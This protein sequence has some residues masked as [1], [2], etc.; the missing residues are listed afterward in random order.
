MLIQIKKNSKKGSKNQIFLIEKK[1]D[2]KSLNLSKEQQAY[3]K[4]E[5][6][7]NKVVFTN[8]SGKITLI[9]MFKSLKDDSNKEAARKLGYQAYEA[10]KGLCKDL[11]VISKN[12]Q[13][14]ELF[15]EGF[16]LSSYYFD[17]YLSEDRKPKIKLKSVSTKNMEADL[18]TV[19]QIV[20]G[21]IWARDLVNEPLSYLTATQFAEDIKKTCEPHGVKVE[22]FK[23]Q[24]I[25]SLKMGGLLA[26]N[27][28]SFDPPTFTVM[29]W[30]P[31]NA[32]NKKPIVLVGKG[33]VYDTGGL[34]LKPTAKS[35]DFMKSDM[36]GA[37]AMV[38]TTLAIAKL[39]LPLHIITLIP[40]TDNRPGN[41]AYA[42]GDII[43]MFDG[44]TVEVL[45]T[46]AEGRMVLADALAYSNKFKPELVIDAA[47]L[48]GAAVGAIGTYSSICMGNASQKELNALNKAGFASFDRVVQFPFWDEYGEEMKSSIAD[49]K[50]LGGPYGGMITAGKFLE[51]FTN[52]PYIHID[53]A[54][55][56]Y[57]HARQSY[58]GLGGTGAGVSLLVEFLRNKAK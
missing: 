20:D 10:T 40:A 53:L 7:E 37:A 54:G 30:K 13:A 57:T 17:K 18:K 29:E 52:F 35:M 4:E 31:K 6:V 44:T 27:K 22:I 46:D 49:L 36:G 58:R 45:N 3:F 8:E 19:N 39:K 43:N 48:T 11:E 33:I 34:S 1:Q 50:N 14:I 38:G 26:V 28:G 55:P 32:K 42:P 9:G 23:K 51:H 25:E 12:A 21:I 16:S 56:A 47:T 2:I 5:A 15:A 41:N 24:K